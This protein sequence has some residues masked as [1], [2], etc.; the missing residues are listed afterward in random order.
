MLTLDNNIGTK[1]LLSLKPCL[2]TKESWHEFT[3]LSIANDG[4]GTHE[5]H[6][7]GLVSIGQTSCH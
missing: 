4:G 3:I 1:M 7:H 6:S 5:E 2:S